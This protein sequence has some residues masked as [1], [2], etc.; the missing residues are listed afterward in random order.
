MIRALRA[1]AERG[2]S[3]S[4]DKAA[5]P[6]YTAEDPRRRPRTPHDDAVHADPTAQDLNAA[7]AA[8]EM[9]P[10]PPPPQPEAAAAPSQPPPSPQMGQPPSAVPPAPQ[11]EAAAAP[12]QP[13]PS[14]P[15]GPECT[16]CMMPLTGD[17]SDPRDRHQSANAD[18]WGHAGICCWKPFHYTCAYTWCREKTD[19]KDR[20]RSRATE[21][22]PHCP[23]CRTTWPASCGRILQKESSV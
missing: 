16:I 3:T 7:M 5:S 4:V 8:I 1:Q 6:L 19:Y 20:L 9:G 12:S 18:R 23:A 2:E 13:P 15:P 11:P 17:A 21:V 10:P 14:P 22:G